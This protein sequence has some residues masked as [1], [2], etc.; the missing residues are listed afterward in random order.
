MKLA[1]NQE[2][3]ETVAGVIRDV[4]EMPELAVS[5][6]TIAQDVKGWDSFNHINIVLAVE[7]HFGVRFHTTEIE[8]IKSVGELVDLVRDKLRARMPR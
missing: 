5:R 7:A 3:L 6:K 8:E 2:I 1:E 4:L